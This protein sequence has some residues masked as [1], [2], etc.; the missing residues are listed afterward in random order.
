MHANT[1]VYQLTIVPAAAEPTASRSQLIPWP[2]ALEVRAVPAP[3]LATDAIKWVAVA[4]QKLP[5]APVASDGL[6]LSNT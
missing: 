6:P 4:D 2:S 3:V 5:T 1:M